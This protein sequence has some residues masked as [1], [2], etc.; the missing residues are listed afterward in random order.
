MPHTR[1]CRCRPLSVVTLPGHQLTRGL[2]IR[3]ALVRMNRNAARNAPS[4]MK[5]ERGA[6]SSR[7]C[8]EIS[9]CRPIGFVL[10]LAAG[11]L[12][13]RSLLLLLLGHRDQAVH[14]HLEHPPVQR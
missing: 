7:K 9:K 4:R 5:T 13:T 12:G 3:R 1:W 11:A 14:E 6:G 2:R 10:Q 8:W